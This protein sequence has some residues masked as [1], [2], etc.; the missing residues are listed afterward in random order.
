[1][2]KARQG[3]QEIRRSPGAAP[4]LVMGCVVGL[5]ALGMAP[6]CGSG[7]G[8]PGFT[9]WAP[10]ALDGVELKGGG[11]KGGH[12]GNGNGTQHDDHDSDDHSDE[13]WD[14]DDHS[15]GDWDS[16]DHHDEDC[17]HDA[18]EGDAPRAAIGQ[19][20]AVARHL[21]NG[22]EAA[23]DMDAL[24][25]HGGRLFSAVWT[26]QE[27]GGRPLTKGTGAPLSDP[28]SPLVF[29]RGFNRVSAPDANSCA[30]CHNQPF[31]IP[32]GGG[33]IVANVFVLGQRFDFATFDVLD[34][35]PTRGAVDE[36]GAPVTAQ[37][38][39]NSR[40]TLGMFGSGYVEMLARQITADLQAIRDRTAPGERLELTS[41]GISF[42][43]IAR[44]ADGRWD[45]SGVEG[46]PAPSLISVGAD[47]PP[48]LLIRPFHQ[49]GAVIS[50]RQFT[51]NA[52]NHHHGIQA[53]ERFGVGADP[54]G[55]GFV[56]EM[57]VADVTAA[58][59]YQ[60]A[61]AVP[62]RL[63]P[64]D[65]VVE[66]AVWAGEQRFQAIG[67]GGC[68]MPALPLTDGGWVFT[69]P[70]PYNPPGNLR[71]GEGPTV[72]MDLSD[73]HLPSPRLA[74][75]DGVVWVPVF[76]DF[77]LHDICDGP[78]DPNIEPLDMQVAAGSQAFFDGNRRFLTRKLWGVANEPPYFH[79]GQYTT[80]RQAI[81]AHAGEAR[82]VMERWRALGAY[83]QDEVVEFLK[84]LQVLPP[85]TKDRVVDEHL[86]KKSWP[87]RG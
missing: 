56:G 3:E 53:E 46:L 14:S 87:P 74:P 5:W 20:V 18:E 2:G 23:L 60:A 78:G 44:T 1:M 68:H 27:G 55:D 72:A 42:G 28:S 29:P 32:G 70:S 64:D 63:I 58:S 45:V 85:G 62:G 21:A 43:A 24:L 15:G 26:D 19:E 12:N 81:E 54:D 79:H 61:M 48:S 73:S 4:L 40:A 10:I 83:E 76:T 39:G 41:K 34:D 17:D 59:L 38:I 50:L 49:A 86:K 9:E 75:S 71:P 6:G 82:P 16:D 22:E 66:A 25:R 7:G 47:N 31:G 80:M 77:K 67:C 8:G 33:D 65:E 35:V 13:D 57:T 11:G 84:S 69:E 51:N 52:F 37:T 30:G 36:S